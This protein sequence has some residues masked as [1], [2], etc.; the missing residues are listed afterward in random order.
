MTTESAFPRLS[1]S[2]DGIYQVW[3]MC[4]AR[5]VNRRVHEN[6]IYRDMH[7]GP[8]PVDYN[9]WIVRNEHRTILVDTGFSPRAS[10]ERDRPLDFDPIGGLKKIGIDPQAIDDIVITHLHYDH[11]GNI[12][13][14][15]K[16]N[17][18]VQD[19]EVAFA[20]GRCMC[21]DH[22]RFPYYVED[23]VALVRRTYADRVVFHDG[24]DSLLPGITL[25]AFPG[26]AAMVQ[27]VR[28]MTPRGPILLASDTTHYFAN[29]LNMK[30]FVLTVDSAATL[31]SYRKALKLAGGVDRLIPGH[32]PKLRRLYPTHDVN[33]IELLA[34][35]EEPQ[36]ID[37]AELRRTDDF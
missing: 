31:D 28:V 34:L 24:D 30:P 15:G 29:I 18:H 16:A 37:A 5:Q 26:H 21:D 10:A 3:S 2:D 22:L 11:A 33:G 27:A 4:Y 23:V 35:H 20:T 32:D 12:D 25:H 13:R 19:G 8:M 6:F 36:S 7:D 17:F 9:I 14:F 1:S